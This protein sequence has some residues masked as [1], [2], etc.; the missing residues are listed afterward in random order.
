MLSTILHEV[1][2]DGHCG[3]WGW[4][5]GFGSPSVCP[6]SLLTCTCQ[7]LVWVEGGLVPAGI[8]WCS[9]C[10]PLQL[11]SSR[12]GSPWCCTGLAAGMG[13][14]LRQLNPDLFILAG[15]HCCSRSAIWAPAGDSPQMQ[16]EVLHVL[17]RT[18]SPWESPA[19]KYFHGRAVS[20]CL[21]VFVVLPLWTSCTTCPAEFPFP[22]AVPPLLFL[23]PLVPSSTARPAVGCAGVSQAEADCV[24]AGC[25]SCTSCP[26]SQPWGMCCAR[27]HKGFAV[28]F[29][30]SGVW[31]PSVLSKLALSPATDL[32]AGCFALVY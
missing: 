30:W 24:H 23:P 28:G 12:A 16:E 17:T 7:R 31:N 13:H 20:C 26:P 8:W 2:A 32:L 11:H 22:W 10:Q 9:I 4:P 15:R 1:T 19:P 25:S 18:V 21:Q 3:S 6:H 5:E 14:C 27:E 29:S